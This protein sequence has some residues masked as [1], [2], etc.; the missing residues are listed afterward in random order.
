[1]KRSHPGKPQQYRGYGAR[2]GPVDRARDDP[3]A[4]LGGG[5][6]DCLAGRVKPLSRAILALHHLCASK[7]GLVGWHERTD[8]I[9]RDRTVEQSGNLVSGWQ[10]CAIE[11]KNHV[12]WNQV[13][14][15]S[16][17]ITIDRFDCPEL[18]LHGPAQ[19][20][21]FDPQSCGRVPAGVRDDAALGQS[22]QAHRPGCAR[23]R[24]N[25]CHKAFG[26]PRARKDDDGVPAQPDRLL[27]RIID[28]QFGSDGENPCG[29][30]SI[31]P[32]CMVGQPKQTYYRSVRG[33]GQAGREGDG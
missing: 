19:P 27:K 32:V 8:L 28:R 16:A 7:R 18:N 33:C 24:R 22:R 26:L 21:H 4:G 30:G 15:Q 13:R 12:G 5:A 29:C 11:D 10:L 31:G 3:V 1:M 17:G 25:A 23:R 6:Q 9:E 2:N 20:R 14:W